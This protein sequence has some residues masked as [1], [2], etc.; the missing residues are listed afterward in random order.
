M[1]VDAVVFYVCFCSIFAETSTGCRL[2]GSALGR[3]GL[4]KI[5][6]YIFFNIFWQKFKNKHIYRAKHLIELSTIAFKVVK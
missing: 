5:S 1:C 3:K 2:A 4:C 6:D